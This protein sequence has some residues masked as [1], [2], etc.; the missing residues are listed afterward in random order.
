[1]GCSKHGVQHAAAAQQK[2]SSTKWQP[3]GGHD[4]LGGAVQ[5]AP[6]VQLGVGDLQA[7]RQAGA[8]VQLGVG[9]LQASNL[10]AGAAALWLCPKGRPRRQGCT[11]SGSA[12]N[13]GVHPARECT[14]S[15]GAPNPGVRPIQLRPCGCNASRSP[16]PGATPGCWGEQQAIPAAPCH[17]PSQLPPAISTSL[18]S[19]CTSTLLPSLVG[20]TCSKRVGGNRRLHSGTSQ[21]AA[22]CPAGRRV[23]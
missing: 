9:D 7:G 17:K 21:G 4:D 1:M 12:P 8:T 14:Q 20:V 3:T 11:Q 15:G 6:L 19:Y 2:G 13:Q 5:L 10:A 18:A 22:S 16:T 23:H